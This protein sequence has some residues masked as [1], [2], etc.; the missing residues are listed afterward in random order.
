MVR[1]NKT[2]FVLTVVLF[3]I[4]VLIALYIH[5]TIIR[6]YVGDVLVVILI[7]CFVRSFVNI[8]VVP[9]AVFVLIFVFVIETLQFINIVEK[10]KLEDSNIVL[11]RF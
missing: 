5:D 6:P 9:A 7:Y 1:F 3:L 10:L 8:R 2:Y 4:E 11:Y